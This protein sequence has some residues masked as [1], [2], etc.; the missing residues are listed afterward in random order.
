MCEFCHRF[1]LD[2]PNSFSSEIKRLAYLF[3]SSWSSAVQTKT[4]ADYFR[5]AVV[6]GQQCVLNS[7]GKSSL[8]IC[9]I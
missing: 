7:V 2:L 9:Q 6:D 8:L 4:K 5:G 3:E 1:A